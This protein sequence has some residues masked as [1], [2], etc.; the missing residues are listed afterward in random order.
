MARH[1]ITILNRAAVKNRLRQEREGLEDTFLPL[2]RL[3]LDIRDPL[4]PVEDRFTLSLPGERPGYRLSETALRQLAGLGG[5]PVPFLERLP[6]SLGLSTLRSCL[7]L[8]MEQRQDPAFLLRIRSG[9]RPR[10]RAFLPSSFPRFDDRDVLAEVLRVLDGHRNLQVTSFA[11]TDD[12]FSLRLVFPQRLNLGTSKRPDPAYSG[13]D[14]RN[15]ETGVRPLEIRRVLHRLVCSNGLTH[16]TDGQRELRA[17]KVGMD[18]HRF[19]EVFSRSLEES[20]RWGRDSAGRL[21]EGHARFIADPV[22][23]VKGIF[24]KYRLGNAAGLP[25]RLVLDELTRSANLLGVSRFDL[26]QAFTSVAQ[27]LDHDRR[28][29]FEDAM[30]AY[31]FQG[32]SRN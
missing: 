29:R 9:L 13:I 24:R 16:V 5:M 26:V 23:E 30:G 15:S 1:G 22:A 32:L 6:A 17:Q 3:R 12:L 10:I 7:T 11:V 27:R 31:L 18:R 28:L 20:L 14:V 4:A 8:L 2:S 21:G 25:G 19:R